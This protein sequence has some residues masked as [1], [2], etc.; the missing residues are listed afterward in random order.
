MSAPKRTLDEWVTVLSVAGNT[1]MVFAEGPSDAHL[2]STIQ[3]F[4]RNVDFRS[5]DEIDID[6]AVEGGNRSRIIRLAE[7]IEKEK[8]ENFS[9]L[10]DTDFDY[11]FRFINSPKN[12]H[13]TDYSNIVSGSISFEF[14]S[15]FLLRGFN[16]KFSMENW[17]DLKDHLK[18]VFLA[19]YLCGYR[20]I[21]HSNVDILNVTNFHNGK[22][23]FK[24]DKF[25]QS[26][27][28][29]SQVVRDDLKKEIQIYKHW[30]TDDDRH[31]IHSS[32]LFYYVHVLLRKS[33]SIGG[34]FPQAGARS[35]LLGALPNDL[36]GQNAISSIIAWIEA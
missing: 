14:I 17:E 3:D 1:K 32:D 16:L 26:F 35:A 15:S 7:R 25:I 28:Q 27:V 13:F 20:N 8:L 36:G 23:L 21:P 5:A 4:G 2:L 6:G 9:C 12:I 29:S 22:L 11:F 24:Y 31:F 18:T 10:I 33:G 30:L 19:R 34:A